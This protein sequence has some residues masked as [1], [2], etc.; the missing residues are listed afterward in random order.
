MNVIIVGTGAVAAE[1]TS[2]IE[3]QNR[4]G[5]GEPLTLL[6]YLDSEEN[7]EKYWAKYKLEKPV[8]ADVQSYEIK[9]DDHFIIG[10][11]NLGFRMQMIDALKAKGANIIAFTHYSSIVAATAKLGTGNIIYPHC[12][13]GPNTEIGD[14]NLVT[15]YSFISHDCVIGS[16]NFFSTAGISGRVSVG[17][18]NFFGIRSTVIPHVAIG[19]G[20]TIQA[21]M[22]VDKNVDD[23]TTV[24]YRF[25]EK[26][27]AIP[28][29]NS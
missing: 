29:E 12:I 13:I 15:S 8:L 19:S 20:N 18:N 2:Y 7:I 26:V 14:F 27:M 9:E 25:K 23:D 16:N 21:G 10:I 5:A 6:G 4:H 1:L 24:F 3:D 22:M 28:K 17:D 11:S